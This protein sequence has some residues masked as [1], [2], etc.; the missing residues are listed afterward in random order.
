MGNFPR[1][2]KWDGRAQRLFPFFIHQ[3]SCKNGE[4]QPIQLFRWSGE[5]TAIFSDFVVLKRRA[6]PI[7]DVQSRHDGARRSISS[8]SSSK[9]RIWLEQKL[10]SGFTFAQNTITW[11]LTLR[12]PSNVWH[13]RQ[14]KSKF[15]CCGAMS[16]T[17][18]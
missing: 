2:G 16:S 10:I 18:S 12:I 6:K 1:D 11:I 3:K 4:R 13:R 17:R 8:K 5:Q 7:S 14:P 15:W 9:R